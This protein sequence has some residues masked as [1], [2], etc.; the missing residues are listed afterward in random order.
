M[1]A[2]EGKRLWVEAEYYWDYKT[3]NRQKTVSEFAKD[4]QQFLEPYAIK[5]V[6]IDPSAAALKLDLNKLGVHTVNANNEVLDGIQMMTSEMAMGNLYVLKS[7]PNLI[8]EIEGYVW[9]ETKA[10]QGE[11]APKK[12]ADHAIDALRYVIATHKVNTYNPYDKPDEGFNGNGDRYNPRRR[13][14]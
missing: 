13:G 11:D 2:Q 14:F 5:A 10:R 8:R 12:K 7:C 4:M 6:Y 3:T 1:R 9:D